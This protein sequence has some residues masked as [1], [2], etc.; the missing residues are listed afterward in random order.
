M[1]Y[2]CIGEV[3]GLNLCGTPAILTGILHGFPLTVQA[4]SG[5]TFWL[6]HEGFL[7]YSF[8][9]IIHQFIPAFDATL[10]ELLTASYNIKQNFS[11]GMKVLFVKVGSSIQFISSKIV[12]LRSALIEISR[13]CL[14]TPGVF[15]DSF[16]E[17][18]RF[19]FSF[20]KHYYMNVYNT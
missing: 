20:P 13:L 14:C 12:P 19:H 10:S 16:Q 11:Y 6:G 1:F 8:Q 3:L 18:L 2:I 7:P 15:D 5:I 9:L 4:N 17:Q